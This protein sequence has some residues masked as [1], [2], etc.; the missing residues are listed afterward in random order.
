MA[1]TN[2]YL[3]PVNFFYLK[4]IY[5][6]DFGDRTHKAVIN[7]QQSAFGKEVVDGVAGPI[8]L[9]ELN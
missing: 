7:V 2:N 3:S 4:I 8:T 9:A 6:G 5:D 1:L